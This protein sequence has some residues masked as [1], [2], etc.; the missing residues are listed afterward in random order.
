MKAGTWTALAAAAASV[1]TSVA[2]SLAC[3]P[4]PPAPPLFA[5]EIRH[6]QRYRRIEVR[7]SSDL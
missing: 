6:S 4:P 5:V 3:S 2:T 1:A 7:S